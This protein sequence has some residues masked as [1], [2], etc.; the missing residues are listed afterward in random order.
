MKALILVDVQNDFVSGGALAVPDGDQIVPIAN[1][2][3]PQFDRTIA[4]Q[5]WHPADHASFASQHE[6][7]QVGDVIDLDGLD[8][9]LWP[10]H[11]VQ[12]TP[13]ADFVNALNLA[14]IDAVI[15]KGT[16]RTIDSYS[17]FFDN[18][19][20]RATGLRDYLVDQEIREIYIC[21]LATDYCVK[22]TA[23][24]ARRLGFKT[25]LILD[26]CRGV[27]L[28]PRD[29]QRAL[30]QLRQAGVRVVPSTDIAA[31]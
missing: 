6:G 9:I 18:G 28:Q 14:R 21:G 26:A 2:I 15:Q 13:G 23:L 3:M 29:V 16:D 30:E 4:T 19:Q 12:D 8:Q 20:R 10:D 17:G 25:H 1:R 7:K 5:D 27:N 31:V 11:C 22:Y 24:D